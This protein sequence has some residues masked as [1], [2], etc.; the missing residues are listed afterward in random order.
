MSKSHDLLWNIVKYTILLLYYAAA[1]NHGCNTQTTV[2]NH[3]CNTQAAAQTAVS[4]VRPALVAQT[5]SGITLIRNY[6]K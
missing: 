5:S 1:S 3:G 2:S 6:G 4:N